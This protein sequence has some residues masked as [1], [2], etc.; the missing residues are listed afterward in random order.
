M[1]QLPMTQLS[2]LPSEHDPRRWSNQRRW[3]IA[4]IIWNLV[5]PIDI[6]ATFY[7]GIQ[8][9]VQDH[10]GTT[11]TFAT[12]GVGLYNVGGI[13]GVLIGGPSSE[14]YGRRPVY[15]VSSVGFVSALG[16]ALSPTI[17]CLLVCRYLS[18][19]FGSPVFATYGG[20]LA[21][22]FSPDERGPILAL[23]TL[24][25]QVPETEANAIER[26][27]L[28]SRGVVRY[29]KVT[30]RSF[31]WDGKALLTPMTM[32]CDE[33]ILIWTTLYHSFVFGLLFILLEA[34]PYIYHSHYSMSREQ[35]GL[36]FISP[37]IGNVLGVAVYFLSLKPKYE[38]RQH[39]IQTESGGKLDIEPE[40]RL[41]GILLASLLMPAGL[42]W[43]T[44]SAY[45]DVHYFFSVLSGVP[46]G[47]GITLFHLSL[48]NYY[49]DLY[50][51]KSASAIA[52]NTAV[53][54]IVSGLLPSIGLPLYKS[55]GIRDANLLLACISCIG[56]PTGVVL[57]VFGRRLRAASRW[58]K[59][60]GFH[61]LDSPSCPDATEPLLARAPEN[62]Y[63]GTTPTC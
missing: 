34:Y 61:V 60:T 56:L 29:A 39:I 40:A 54:N 8:Q 32:L 53:R 37:F 16:A 47:I 15:I 28:K 51:T 26:K 24:V 6:A 48:I 49:I 22:L 12:L 45:P 63:G 46:V 50:P 17:T 25:L 62:H 20:S 41:P 4:F 57:Y 19:L 36:V 43:F 31:V 13:F 27:L 2:A 42:F 55:L 18:G 11:N 9:Q 35:A 30:E 1:T 3:A 23:F 44:F 33:P 52:A 38:I 59:Q 14:I 7:S 5:A 21:D 10:F 58:A